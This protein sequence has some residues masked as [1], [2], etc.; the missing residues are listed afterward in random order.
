MIDDACAPPQ[1]DAT[2]RR[3]SDEG[4]LAA[5]SDPARARRAYEEA[6]VEAER[7]LAAAE[8]PGSANALVEAA[9]VL[10]VIACQ[11]AAQLERRRGA[12]GAAATLVARAFD[13]IVA[14]AAAPRAPRRLRESCADNLK[15]V[16]EAVIEDLPAGDVEGLRPFVERA[17][18]AW[19]AVRRSADDPAGARATLASGSA[20]PRATPDRKAS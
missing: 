4:N 17:M 19:L 1:F 13:R 16:L 18:A 6:I 8:A 9:P 14:T 11:N 15:H 20:A 2:W 12:T 3:L 5:A 7:L 10:V